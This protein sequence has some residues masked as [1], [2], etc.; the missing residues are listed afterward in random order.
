M[1]PLEDASTLASTSTSDRVTL[2]L[3][4]QKLADPQL[5]SS[6]GS[7]VDIRPPGEG[8]E[9]VEMELEESLDPEP[10]FTEGGQ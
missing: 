1:A 10:C 3:C 5:S 4:P 8:G 9:S 6:E 2:L 7:T